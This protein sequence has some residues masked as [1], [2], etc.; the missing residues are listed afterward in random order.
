MP[1]CTTIYSSIALLYLIIS[2]YAVI[3]GCITEA[4]VVQYYHEARA[5]ISEAGFNLRA[6]ASNSQQPCTIAMQHNTSDT[7]IPTNVLSL[8][9]NALTDKL[10]L[11]LE[12]SP[13]NQKP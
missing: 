4:E 3:S 5:I 10:S 1:H 8:Y 11:M 7:N 2:V 6:W 12:N 9:W 13:V